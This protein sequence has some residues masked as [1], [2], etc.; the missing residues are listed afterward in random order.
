[1]TSC[2]RVSGGLLG[3][4]TGD[5]LGVPVEFKDRAVLQ[6]DPVK[7]MR[8]YGTHNQ[9]SGTWSDDSSLLLCGTESLLECGYDLHDMGRR[10]VAWF[11]GGLWRPYGQVFDIGGTTSVAISNLATG[12]PPE[13]CG[14]NNDRDNGNGSLMRILPVAL[15]TSGRKIDE[16]VDLIC[17]ASC[18]THAHRRCQLA[19]AFYGLMVRALF[20]GVSPK[21]S[22]EY[23]LKSITPFMDLGS[24][25]DERPNFASLLSGNLAEKSE[26]EIFSSGYVVD[27]LTAAIWCLLKTGSFEDCLLKAVNLG[28]D[29][30]TTTSV[31][32]G[33][34]GVCYGVNTIP[35]EWVEAL[36]RHEKI[37]ALCALFAEKVVAETG[38]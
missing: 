35:I 29:T 20:K 26:E 10:F 9:P 36:A 28:G 37:T 23:A 33:L 11:E 24:F 7:G 2:E 32:G 4:I 12:E 31:T 5:A 1:M 13:E 17:R 15:F 19:C 3:A 38:V 25:P 8:G 22:Y 16:Q 18:L 27:T 14:G 21:T 30:D 6:E 34:A